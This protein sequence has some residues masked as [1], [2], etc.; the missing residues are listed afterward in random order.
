MGERCCICFQP[1]A[2]SQS[3]QASPLQEGRCCYKCHYTVVLP[4]RI[5]RLT[6]KLGVSFEP[7]GESLN[8]W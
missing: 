4:E 1:L 5:K 7:P 8:D 6:E 2:Q 3:H